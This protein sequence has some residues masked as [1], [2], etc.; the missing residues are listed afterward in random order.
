MHHYRVCGYTVVSDLDLPGAIAAPPPGAAPDVRVRRG[1]VPAT[2][3][4]ASHRGPNWAM[5]DDR[6]MLR[7]PGVARFL[8]AQG[9][10]I[11]FETE[12]GTS[13]ADAAIFLLGSAFGILLHQRGQMVLHASA[14]SV[15]GKAVLFCGPSG[16]GKST[17]AAALGARGFAHVNDD[18]CCLGSDA[19]G[20]PTIVPDGRMLKL[21]A[22]AVERLDVAE[23]KGAAVRSQMEKFYVEPS[24]AAVEDA[25]PIG[26]I[27]MLR[28]ERPSLAR[29]IEPLSPLDAAILLRRNA[30]RPRLM[31]IMGL[32][33]RFFRESSSL[34]R[35][36]GLFRLTRPLDFAMMPEVADMLAAHWRRLGLLETAR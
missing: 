17:I 3:G 36:A 25:L 30:Y 31:R 10:E 27:Y 20:R 1:A 29:G 7:V 23:H 8:I 16:A 22:D 18:V 21:W 34:Q 5:T 24:S 35:H 33:D 15:S 13:E 2:L 12:G 14:V 11:L 6:F 32:A 9:R 19:D 28:R 4:E 26:A